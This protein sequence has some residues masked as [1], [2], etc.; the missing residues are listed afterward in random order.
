MLG[1]CRELRSQGAAT[2]MPGWSVA[3]FLFLG[4]YLQAAASA[5]ELTATA[6]PDRTHAATGTTPFSLSSISSPAYW[7]NIDSDLPVSRDALDT[8]WPAVVRLPDAQPDYSLS[9]SGMAGAWHG[10][11]REA[12]GWVE[13]NPTHMLSYDPQRDYRPQ[14][15]LGGP[16]PILR[17][18]LRATGLDAS[19]CLAPL[20]RMHS[21]ISGAGP[22]TNVSVSARCNFH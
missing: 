19:T 14:F 8:R 17:T 22:H 13:F 6:A 11:D 21:T 2:A 9:G 20:M 4:L 10:T 7:L 16:S 12:P 1:R 18:L 5:A 15:A 3:A